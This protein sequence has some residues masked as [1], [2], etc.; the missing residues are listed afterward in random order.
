MRDV[1]L[2]SLT[3]VLAAVAL[4]H[5]WVGVM[6]WTWLSIMNPHKLA[7]AAQT[8]PLAALV[9]GCTLLGLVLTRDKRHFYVTPE[10]ALLICFMLWMCITLPF[11]FYPERS[12]PMWSRVLKIDFM[13]LVTLVLLYSKRH[14]MAFA[15]VVVFSLGFYGVKGGIF[16]IAHGGS[17]LVWGPGGSFIEGNNEIALALIMTIPLMRFLQLQLTGT[18]ARRGLTM[19]MFLSAVAAVGTHSR[20]AFLAIIAMGFFFWLR[21][22]KKWLMTFMVPLVAIVLIALMPA[23][24]EDRMATIQTYEQ[25]NSAMDRIRA[26]QMAY[27]LAKDNFFGGGFDIY[28]RAL[29][30]IYA[31]AGSRTAAAHSIYFQ[32]L[33]EHGF[34]GLFLF[35]AMWFATWRSAGWL[36]RNCKKKP[37]YRWASQL[38]GMCQVSLVG[39]AVGG[40]FLS[41]AYFD[42]PYNIMVLVILSKRLVQGRVVDDQVNAPSW[43]AFLNRRTPQRAT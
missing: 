29:F 30:A 32:V 42:L 20:G 17:Y 11:S 8:L 33:G 4:I 15:S 23:A 22:D 41:L 27:A 24:W 26:W 18:W 7:W 1:V 35:L 36:Y 2:V 3:V 39:Y 21:S 13:I 28:Q 14:I 5:P 6:T 10:S 37:E 16:T 40:A 25:D 31:P 19:A 43:F 34:V 9:A 38:G 12:F